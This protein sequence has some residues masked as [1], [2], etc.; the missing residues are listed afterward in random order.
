MI[1]DGEMGI[2]CDVVSDGL[3]VWIGAGDG[4]E[5]ASGQVDV[6]V[7]VEV[8]RGVPRLAVQ[9]VKE[10]LYEVKSNAMDAEKWM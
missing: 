6:T 2:G 10:Q 1:G 9:E 8:D 4:W 3:A 5:G 7:G